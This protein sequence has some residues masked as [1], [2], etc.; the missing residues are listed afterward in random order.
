MRLFLALGTLLLMVGC[1]TP[2]SYIQI[3]A[4]GE[5]YH[6]AI[7]KNMDEGWKKDRSAR[8]AAELVVIKQ[9]AEIAI[10]KAA[11]PDGKLSPG[12][13]LGAMETYII[14]VRK[15]NTELA[16]SDAARQDALADNLVYKTFMKELR[17]YLSKQGQLTPEQIQEFGDKVVSEGNRVLD[18]RIEERS[19][20][21]DAREAEIERRMAE[22]E[23]E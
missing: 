6:H 15:L 7:V 21:L 4:K 3:A 9:K 22:L 8:E 10:Q 13:A 5:V 19:K 1:K 11:G 14:S 12:A 2:E 16:K 18:L 17:G 23:E 20:E